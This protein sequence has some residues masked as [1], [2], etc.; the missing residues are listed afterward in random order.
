MGPGEIWGYYF[1]KNQ[2]V[3]LM[4]RNNFHFHDNRGALQLD[5]SIPVIEK[6]GFQI[7]YFNGYGES[8]L[9]YNHHVNRIGIGFILTDW[10]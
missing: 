4:L 10:I 9:D 8:L 3:R 7:Q 5:W 1:W 2:R 6:I